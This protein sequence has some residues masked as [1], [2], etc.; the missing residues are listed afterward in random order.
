MICKY[1]WDISW[2]WRDLPWWWLNE[3]ETELEWL[4]RE[5]FEEIWLKEYQFKIENVINKRY[6]KKYDKPIMWTNYNNK[7]ITYHWKNET[8][9]IIKIY[10]QKINLWISNEFDDY[11]WINIDEIDKYMK[12][13]EKA[14]FI[15]KY[16]N[17]N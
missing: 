2:L 11:K 5:I 4:K 14:I 9:Y 17:I 8:F 15:K 10:E 1:S 13:K 7:K 6:Y 3:N 12:N 16:S